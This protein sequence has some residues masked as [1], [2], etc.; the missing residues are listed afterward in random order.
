M[1]RQNASGE[2]WLMEQRPKNMTMYM[3]CVGFGITTLLGGVLLIFSLEQHP[4]LNGLLLVCWILVVSRVA[5][6]WG[7]RI[8]KKLGV[9]W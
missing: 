4:I 6:V 7:P 9:V 2:G 3:F 5:N 8:A 1:Y